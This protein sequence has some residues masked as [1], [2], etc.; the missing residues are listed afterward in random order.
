MVRSRNQDLRVILHKDGDTWVLLHVDHHDPA[1]R[2]AER[3]DVGRHPVTGALQIVE[4]VE[5]I[6]EIERVVHV[7][8]AKPPIF[9]HRKQSDS[10]LL[11]LGIPENWLPTLRTV[12][13]DDEQLASVVEKLP[14]DVAL[15]IDLA[16]GSW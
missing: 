12:T 9:S 14:A 7:E 3:R 2:W 13:D 1:Y 6:R 10:Y 16:A 5:T 11:S 15:R 8:P 4:S